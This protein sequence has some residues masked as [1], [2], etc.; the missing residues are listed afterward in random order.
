MEKDF[1]IF[2]DKNF[3]DLSQEIY[4]NSKLKKTQIELLVQEVHGYIQGIEDIAV[5]GPILKELL[6]VGVK[7]DDNLLKLATVFQRIMMKS[8]KDESDIGLLSD[9]EKQQLMDSLEDA[10]SDIQKKQDETSID[11][12]RDKYRSA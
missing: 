10:A 7:N 3:S 4:E 9:D 6:D 12:I 5:V 11:K 8:G 2:G 1:K